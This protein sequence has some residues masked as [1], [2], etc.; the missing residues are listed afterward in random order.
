MD[1]MAPRQIFI[2]V[3]QFSS[4]TI[5]PPTHHI[6][7][8]LIHNLIRKT[9][10]RCLENSTLSKI[11]GRGRKRTFIFLSIKPWLTDVFYV[12]YFTCLIVSKRINLNM[13]LDKDEDIGHK[14]DRFLRHRG[15]PEGDYDCNV[16]TQYCIRFGYESRRGSRGASTSGRITRLSVAE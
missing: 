16:Q 2:R 1:K 14:T 6:N 11:W 5:I 3:L 8:R 15:A 9:S 12:F 7:L 4:V 13:L 10:R